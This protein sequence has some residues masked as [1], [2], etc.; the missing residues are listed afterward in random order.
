MNCEHTKERLADWLNGSLSNAE[1]SEVERHLIH[2]MDCQEEFATSNQMWATM[3]KIKIDVPSDPMRLQFKA[4]LGEF[5]QSVKEEQESVVTKW[6]S[7]IRG[8][9]TPQ[10]ALQLTFSFLLVGLGWFM[11]SRTNRSA[12]PAVAYERQIDTLANQVQ[13]MKQMMMLALIEN[14]S[15]TERLRAVS[16]TS[17][18]TQADERVREAL[19]MTLNNDPNVNVRLVTLEALTQFASDPLVRKELV[20]SLSQQ[21]SPMVQVALADLMVKLQEKRSIKAFRDM[22]RK[23]DLNDLVKIK[24]EQTIK[25]LS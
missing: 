4:M 25:D 18:I 2:C 16:Y 15:A 20:K 1:K 24:I 21:D 17:D 10:L 11:G 5:K 22:L 19:F 9:L 13:E 3:S 6:L 14:P 7:R 12:I 23:E 8:L